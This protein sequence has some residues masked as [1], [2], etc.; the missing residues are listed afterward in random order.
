V[1]EPGHRKGAAGTGRIKSFYWFLYE[2][3][4]REPALKLISVIRAPNGSSVTASK[5]NGEGAG[6]PGY[7]TTFV[8]KT[9]I[10]C[11]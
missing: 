6:K 11:R 3:M 5:I 4:K 10:T 1:K 2:K 9:R 7:I 8:D